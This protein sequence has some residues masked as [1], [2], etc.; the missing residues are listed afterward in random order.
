VK[1][2]F[3]E[4]HPTFVKE[5][6]NKMKL[7]IEKLKKQGFSGKPINRRNVQLHWSFERL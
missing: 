5:G 2:I 6:E 4:W 1:S 3:I 7:M